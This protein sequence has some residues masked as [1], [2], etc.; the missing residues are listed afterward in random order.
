VNCITG[1]IGVGVGLV[2]GGGAQIIG[3]AVTGKGFRP[4]HVAGAAAGGAVTGGVIGATGQV[5]VGFAAGG[6]TQSVTTQLLTGDGKVSATEVVVDTAVSA[7]VGKVVPG[8]KVPGI[9]SGNGSMAHVAKTQTTRLANGQIS[10]VAPKTVGKAIVSSGVGSSGQN[11]ATGIA[12]DIKTGT[13]EAAN[14][15]G[16]AVSSGANAISNAAGSLAN[17]IPQN[18]INDCNTTGPC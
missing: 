3:D 6:A 5:G 2:A 17:S 14:N 16:N 11:I 9:T 4:G 1:A 12:G 18:P 15:L 7:T 13:I 10:S 8:V